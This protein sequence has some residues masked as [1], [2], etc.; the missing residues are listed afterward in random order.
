[1]YQLA[2]TPDSIH[3]GASK[4]HSAYILDTPTLNPTQPRLTLKAKSL[5]GL[6]NALRKAA[7]VDHKSC[8]QNPCE[9]LW[10]GEVG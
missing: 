7:E 3:F 1:M 9:A 6:P 10:A 8:V 5:L 4:T 2:T